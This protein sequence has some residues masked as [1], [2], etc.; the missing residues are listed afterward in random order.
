[1]PHAN[2][3]IRKVNEEA[4]NSLGKEKSAFVNNALESGADMAAL[5]E[6][7][8]P[9]DGVKKPIILPDGTRRYNAFVTCTHPNVSKRTGVCP[10]C[11]EYT[12]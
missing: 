12:R 8:K 9:G 11:G 7:R 6:L 10:D 1:V 2:I 4:W 3:W 5:A